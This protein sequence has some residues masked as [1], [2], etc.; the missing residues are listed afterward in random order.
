M[1]TIRRPLIVAAVVAATA[2][3]AST[4][5]AVINGQASTGLERAVYKHSTDQWFT[6]TNAWVDIPGAQPR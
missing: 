5:T 2:L 1:P 4:A 6:D 3:T